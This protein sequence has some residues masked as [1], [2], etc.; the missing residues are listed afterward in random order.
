MLTMLKPVKS[1]DLNLFITETRFIKETIIY[2]FNFNE[3]ECGFQRVLFWL[4]CV[5]NVTE[6]ML[7]VS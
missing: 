5:E 3:I 1:D 6:M 2:L 4:T 7:F